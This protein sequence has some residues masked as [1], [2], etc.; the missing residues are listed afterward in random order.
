MTKNPFEVRLDVLK[1]A[2]GMLDKK[3]DVEQTKYLTQSSADAVTRSGQEP[4]PIKMYS[5][6][7]VNKTFT[8]LYNFVNEKK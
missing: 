3:M 2:L 4:E 6:D 8:T 1:L 5:I 7:D